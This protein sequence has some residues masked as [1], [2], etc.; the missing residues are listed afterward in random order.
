MRDP[1]FTLSTPEASRLVS[2][3]FG[4]VF[5]RDHGRHQD[6]T[7]PPV[8]L[9]HGMLVTSHSFTRLIPA[10]AGDRRVLAPDLPG[11]GDSDRPPPVLCADYS[12]RW[13]A[14]ALLELLDHLGLARIDLV[15]HSWG[16][17]IAVCLIDAA[18]ERVR[19]LVLVDP[20]LMPMVIPIEG[21]LAQVPRLGPYV[22][23]N[24]Y[25]RNEL[26]RY[27]GRAFSSEHLVSEADVDLYWDRLARAGGREAAHAM[28]MQL[29]QPDTMAAMLPR[30]RAIAAPTVVV[31]GERDAIV[32]H[33]HA[34]RITAAIPGATLRWLPGC[35]HTPAEE[36][37]E[38]LAAV[39]HEHL[40]AAQLG[41]AAPGPSPRLEA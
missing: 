33:D 15:G 12:P 14:A 34:E 21:R 13:Q 30:L 26:R 10:L 6:P 4:R 37:P 27:L 32:P 35:G 7:R 22:F 24:M 5:L 11:C 3:S 31:F 9:L 20:T 17:A 23:K 18:P 38:A 25:R 16:G 29:M 8:L 28:L 19:R 2:L 1:G 41:P 40:D 39:L 36:Q